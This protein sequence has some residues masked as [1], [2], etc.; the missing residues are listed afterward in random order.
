MFEGLER[1]SFSSDWIT[2]I[3]MLVL[4]LI[5]ILKYSFNERFTKL[6]SLLYSEKYYTDYIK[7]NPLLFN[8]FHIYFFFIIN[9]NISL[10]IYFIFKAYSPINIKNDFQFYSLILLILISYIIL[11]YLL[12]VLLAYVLDI[13]YDQKYFT[14]LKISNL[15]L[16]S[17]LLFPLLI[18]INYSVGIFHKFLIIFGLVTV[19]ILFIIRYFILVKNEKLNFNNLFY[20]FLYLCALELS[21]FIVIYKLFVD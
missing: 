9:F 20:L 13:Y 18:L 12:G 6:F 15:S 8:N 2:I 4:V 17:I 3:F 19:L 16:I 21:P 1:T 10:F 14:F 7:T 11:R 5:T